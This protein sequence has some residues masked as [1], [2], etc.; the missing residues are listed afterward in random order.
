MR[1][2]CVKLSDGKE[3]KGGRK[4]MELALRMRDARKSAAEIIEALAAAK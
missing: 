1:V 3:I 4:A 2:A